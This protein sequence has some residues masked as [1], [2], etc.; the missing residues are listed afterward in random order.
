MARGRRRNLETAPP[1]PASAPDTAPDAAPEPEV[2]EEDTAASGSDDPVAPMPIGAAAV[3][4]AREQSAPP[5]EHWTNRAKTVTGVRGK[6]DVWVKI[7]D[8]QYPEFLIVS[9]E[10]KPR[11][12]VKTVPNGVMIYER[13]PLGDWDRIQTLVFASMHLAR[14][15]GPEPL[16]VSRLR[17]EMR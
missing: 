5:E 4:E 12:V 16:I 10:K 11:V 7:E 15:P 3:M 6:L 8:A 14:I 17:Q 13:N 2:P 9:A 1:E